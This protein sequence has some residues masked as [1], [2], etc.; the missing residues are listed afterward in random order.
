MMN[1][2]DVI[3]RTL[4]P[5]FMAIQACSR[6]MCTHVHTINQCVRIRFQVQNRIESPRARILQRTRLAI[7]FSP[8]SLDYLL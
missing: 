1:F 3:L 6:Y 7:Y 4:F 2:G 5:S 8:L